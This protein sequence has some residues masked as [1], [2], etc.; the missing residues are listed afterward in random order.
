MAPLA[1]IPVP[2]PPT[3]I[4][5]PSS[6]VPSPPTPVSVPP[7]PVT[8]TSNEAA[9]T[10]TLIA[11]DRT[12]DD[13]DGARSSRSRHRPQGPSRYAPPTC[14]GQS[15]ILIT[16]RDERNGM[17]FNEKGYGINT[18]VVKMMAEVRHGENEKKVYHMGSNAKSF[19]KTQAREDEQ[20]NPGIETNEV[21]NV[22]CDAAWSKHSKEAGLGFCV[23]D[24]RK[25]IVV[26][27]LQIS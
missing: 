10:P 13:L 4:P 9:S 7:P 2:L 15:F 1:T 19:S 22:Y 27:F 11:S 5:P 20:F 3:T 12:S 24:R 25:A 18:L 21:L 14:K 23:E 26:E 6:T 17:C 16:M 8:T